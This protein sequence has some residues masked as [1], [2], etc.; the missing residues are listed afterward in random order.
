MCAYNIF[1]FQWASLKTSGG[2]FR[3]LSNHQI[4][5]TAQTPLVGFYKEYE[6]SEYLQRAV[7]WMEMPP[8][9]SSWLDRS[10]ASVKTARCD[11]SNVFKSTNATTM[12]QCCLIN[13]VTE[14]VPVYEVKVFWHSCAPLWCQ[15]CGVIVMHCAKLFQNQRM[16]S[17]PLWQCEACIVLR[18]PNCAS[19]NH[20]SN[21][22]S[23]VWMDCKSHYLICQNK[24]L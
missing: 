22:L 10:D 19:L 13:T 20:G 3:K 17:I 12:L 16:H 8:V 2:Q 7:L 24:I 5:G 18:A 9:A 11:S 4:R 23:M 6:N 15:M 21:G 14:H 1:S